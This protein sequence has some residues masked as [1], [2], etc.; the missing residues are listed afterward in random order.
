MYNRYLSQEFNYGP[1]PQPTED[2]PS[3]PPGG[4]GGRLGGLL[5]RLFPGERGEGNRVSQALSALLKNAGLQELDTGDLLLALIV[6]FLILE[7]GDDLELLI[8]LG[9]ML[10]LHLGEP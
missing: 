8:A 1:I 3:P 7:D 6:L 5:G 10:A 9:L 2:P 4:G